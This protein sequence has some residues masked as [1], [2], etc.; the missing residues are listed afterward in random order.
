MG[1]AK[2][3]DLERTLQ[4]LEPVPRPRADIEQY[5]TP[6]GI[7]AE[8]AYMALGRGDLEG[9]TVLD[10]GCGN[11]VLGIAA[12]LL[13]ARDVTGADLDPEA[14]EVAGR[15]ARRV[16]AKGRWV[17]S[18]VRAVEGPFDTVLMNPPFGSQRRH[19]DLP[20]LDAALRLGRVV[21]SFHN[22][23]AEAF[24]LRRIRASGA[25]ITDRLEYAFPLGRAFAF[26]RRDVQRI[27][28]LLLRVEPQRRD[29]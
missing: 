15:N 11:G 29:K 14:V 9:R 23:K 4:G 21:Y 24:V 13:G 19:A 12:A 6:A 18:D 7:A 27:P 22:A 1:P 28:V 8:V 3:T 16:G 10:A 2:K 26:H 5:P 20:F 25:T 17:V